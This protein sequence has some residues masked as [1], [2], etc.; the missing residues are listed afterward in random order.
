MPFTVTRSIFPGADFAGR[1]TFVLCL[2]PCYAFEA[3]QWLP[4]SGWLRALELNG[5]SLAALWA[6]C[7]I[8]LAL[9]ELELLYLAILPTWV[10]ALAAFLGVAFTLL[11]LARV[12]EWTSAKLAK[13]N[14]RKRE[15]NERAKILMQLDELQGR[16]ADIMAHCII[17]GE[18][19]FLLGVWEAQAGLSLV[20]RGLA[21]RLGSRDDGFLVFAI[22]PFVGN[23]LRRRS[24]DLQTGSGTTP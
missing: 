6:A 11:W 3:M 23:E 2:A 12:W 5:S 8:L 4:D 14:E 15:L 10:R 22:P 17:T 18:R 24:E 9:A 1:I 7:W 20:Q 21:Q 16:E 19:V 13:K